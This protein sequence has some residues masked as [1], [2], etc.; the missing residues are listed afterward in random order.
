MGI[1]NGV[2]KTILRPGNGRDSAKK[3]DT[4]IIE[5]R[6]CLYDESSGADNYFMGTQFDTSKG[7]GPL[8]T[9]IGV[10]KVI[11]GWDEGVQQMT[12]GEKAILTISSDYGYGK[13]GFPGLIPPNSGLVFEVELKNILGKPV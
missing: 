10:G 9:E 3:G 4:V 12:L 2:T 7:R 8:K 11:I 6:G 1:L 13:N 5:Y